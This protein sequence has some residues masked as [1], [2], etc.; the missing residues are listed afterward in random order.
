MKNVEENIRKQQTVLAKLNA[1]MERLKTGYE[2]KENKTKLMQQEL[3]RMNMELM[4]IEQ[5]IV[6]N[7]NEV[8]LENLSVKK[9]VC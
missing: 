7:P 2:S 5:Q 9:Q 1:E 8:R 6:P 3:D 4:S